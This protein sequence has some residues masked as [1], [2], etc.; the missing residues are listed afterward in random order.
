MPAKKKTPLKGY[1]AVSD[2]EKAAYQRDNDLKEAFKGEVFDEEVKFPKSVGA[3]HPF[4][5]S[6]AEKVYRKTG[7]V[8]GAVNKYVD[9]I[10]GEF[11][12]SVKN[13]NAEQIIKE[14][15]SDTEFSVVLREW[16]R[17]A[18]IKG[19]GF[20]ELDLEEKK[21]RVLNANDMYVKRT[22]KG[23]IN[24]F[25]QLKPQ[26]AKRR[27]LSKD[28][29]EEFEPQQIAHLKVNKIAGEAYGLGLV[30]PNERV[31]ENIVLYEQDLHKLMT[32]KAGSPWHVKVGQPGE[33]TD[34]AA[35]DGIKNKLTYM[36]TRTEWVTDGNVNIEAISMNDLGKGL[37]DTL[38]HDIEMLSFGM[39]IPI[40]L[41]GAGSIPEGLAKVQ[42]EAWQRKI[43][44]I[45]E[46]IESIIEEK[47]F[48]PILRSESLEVPIQ[49]VWNLPGEEEINA[50]IDKI[51]NLMSN[52]M[53]SP[54]LR[55]Y[56]EL[57]LAKLLEFEDA[58]KLLVQPKDA[59]KM[60]D[61]DEERR[62]EEEEVPQPEV[63]GAKPNANQS[64]QEKTSADMTLQE[65]VNLQEFR[66]FTYTD[67][68]IRILKNL[69]KDKF[70][71]LRAIT[72]EDIRDGLLTESEIEKL[73]VVLKDG[74]KDN[75]TISQIEKQIIEDIDLKD[76]VVK[77]KTTATAV[78]RANG[79]ARTETVRLANKSLI[80][81]YEENDATKYRFLAALSDRTCPICESINGQIF[82]IKEAREGTNLPPMHTACRCSTTAI[83]E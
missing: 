73:R 6:D 64:L 31:I 38:K 41:F 43:A 55:S 58:D 70:N 81:L 76:R 44:A 5:F 82:D 83:I 67:Y 19:N 50:R 9:S 62:R 71:N 65:F 8:C 1:I 59:Q 25:Y 40:V 45:Q 63:P 60:A 66:G 30:W 51:T 61:E 33:V 36:Q 69:A 47:I 77:G 4:N 26:G 72:K 75:K 49:F 57:E 10:V 79:I 32:R 3:E 16:I 22:K 18:M 42:L 14:F 17:E 29:F 24:K 12:I 56:L 80:E 74:F 21:M 53:I 39:E 34:P 23:V 46:D 7:I 52:M 28:D 68:L 15:L 2:L 37:I 48:K 13:S 35:V 54:V 78:S 11:N 27:T 20:L